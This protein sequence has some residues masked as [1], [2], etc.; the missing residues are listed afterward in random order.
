MYNRL[1]AACCTNGPILGIRG[2]SGD[3]VIIDLGKGGWGSYI[4]DCIFLFLGCK[5]T[6]SNKKYTKNI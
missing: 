3:F 6:V 5:N 2:G 1:M 4:H